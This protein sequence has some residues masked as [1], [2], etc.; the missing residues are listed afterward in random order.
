M[1]ALLAPSH[2]VYESQLRG[3]EYRHAFEIADSVARNWPESVVVTGKITEKMNLPYRVI[4]AQPKKTVYEMGALAAILFTIRYSLKSIKLLMREDFDVVHHVRPFKLGATFNLLALLNLT[5]NKIFIIGSFSVP[6]NN[7]K[8]PLFPRTLQKIISPLSHRTL[9][10][11]DC[12]VVYDMVTKKLVSPY[13]DQE[14]IKLIAPGVDGNRFKLSSAKDYFS[15]PFKLVAVGYL[16]PRKRF[17]YLIRVFAET[18][19]ANPKAVLNIYGDGPEMSKLQILISNLGVEKNVF[20]KGFIKNSDLPKV[21][22][23]AHVF[24]LLQQEESYGQ[25]Y[26]EAMAS[27]LPIITTNNIGAKQII[28]DG[29]GYMIKRNDREA[30]KK[31]LTSLMNDRNK[32]RELS[33]GARQEFERKHDSKLVR[34]KWLALYNDLLRARSHYS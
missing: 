24:T 15:E 1:K 30:F 31:I 32:L 20:L 28:N 11:A 14:K 29:F 25:V 33:T 19:K 26:L 7:E 23:D 13:V 6:Y 8:L 12:V 27:S 4:E 18:V 34:K 5:R 3:S 21:Y 10:K 17:D 9:A 16:I 2:Y 22:K